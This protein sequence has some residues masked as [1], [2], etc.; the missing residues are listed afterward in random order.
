MPTS[1]TSGHHGSS[2][3]EGYCLR[4]PTVAPGFRC[5]GV[6]RHG[7]EMKSAP[8]SGPGLTPVRISGPRS[9]PRTEPARQRSRE[10]GAVRTL[11]IDL[12]TTNGSTGVCDVDWET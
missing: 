5:A 10:D 7:F 6:L 11:G 4:A 3:T 8:G 1:A 2:R 9:L 12:A